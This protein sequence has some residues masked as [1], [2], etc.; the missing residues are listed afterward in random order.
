MAAR[1]TSEEEK[2]VRLPKNGLDVEASVRPSDIEKV[3]TKVKIL[4]Y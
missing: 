3:A 2:V 1:V 4:N